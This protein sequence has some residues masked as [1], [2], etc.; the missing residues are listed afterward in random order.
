MSKDFLELFDW[1]KTKNLRQ[2]RI[3]W[4]ECEV[5]PNKNNKKVSSKEVTEKYL[6]LYFN[7]QSFILKE[8]NKREEKAV[9]NNKR[10]KKLK[11]R[12]E[13]KNEEE[14]CCRERYQ[15]CW[16]KLKRSMEC[17]I[18]RKRKETSVSENRK[19]TI[20]NTSRQIRTLVVLHCSF[21]CRR[22][23]S[24]KKSRRVTLIIESLPFP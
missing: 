9:Y 21:C 18:N 6:L 10:K 8:E 24:Q 16:N 4:E 20:R 15:N 22:L 1:C 17:A 12:K 13:K 11:I 3:V 23:Q 7:G 19:Q 14:E 2:T 5:Q